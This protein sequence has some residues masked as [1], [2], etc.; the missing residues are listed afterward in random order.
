[1]RFRR[2]PVA[3]VAFALWIGTALVGLWEIVVI[4]DMLF[5]IYVRLRTASGLHDADYWTA[6]SLGNWLV[7]I[8]S[9]VWLGFAIGTG[10]YHYRRAGQLASWKLFGWTVGVELAILIVAYFV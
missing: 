5:R 6:L 2:V 4:R 1:M 8:L 3:L 7:L 9:V 10:E